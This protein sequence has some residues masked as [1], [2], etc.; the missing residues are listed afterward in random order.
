MDTHRTLYFFPPLVVINSDAQPHKSP[1]PL[2]T[3]DLLQHK[4]ENNKELFPSNVWG[5]IKEATSPIE[6]FMLSCLGV[7]TLKQT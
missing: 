1:L 6:I 2:K 3:E 4:R 7:Q 5:N